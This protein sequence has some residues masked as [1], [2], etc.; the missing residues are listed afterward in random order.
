MS[1]NQLADEGSSAARP[2]KLKFHQI[3]SMLIGLRAAWRSTQGAP[4]RCHHRFQTRAL[5]TIVSFVALAFSIATSATQPIDLPPQPPGRVATIA[6]GRSSPAS[7][8]SWLT[9]HVDMPKGVSFREQHVHQEILAVLLKDNASQLPNVSPCELRVRFLDGFGDFAVGAGHPNPARRLACLRGAIDYL[10]R[11][12]IGEFD[13]GAAPKGR[14]YGRRMGYSLQ[15]YAE[16]L[17][18][19]TIYEKYSPLHE[20]HSV[21]KEDLSNASFEEFDAWLRRSREQKLISF[22]GERT[23]LD[24]LDLPV[25]D[26]MLLV[27]VPSLKSPRMPA[28]VLFFE[29]EKPEVPALI[30]LSIDANDPDPVD[31]EIAD[32]LGCTVNRPVRPGIANLGHAISFVNC[33]KSNWF[34]DGWLSFGV[35][36]SDGANYLD[37]CRQVRE[38]TSD[39]L[40]AAAVRGSP[41]GSKGLYVLLP[42]KCET[43]E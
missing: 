16:P 20:I 24:S 35:G 10:L 40:F 42:P 12:P 19:L 21:G 28:G 29:K 30:M 31:R 6:A 37:Y 8:Q 27:P 26:P 38:L 7:E 14:A 2:K 43:G 23:L 4:M 5:G 18:L 1:I 36:K 41:E 3:E 13:F 15:T 33:Y 34:G 9:Y 17:A 22:A 25:P 11:Q 39:P 32:R